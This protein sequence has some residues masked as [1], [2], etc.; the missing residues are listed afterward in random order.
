MPTHAF[1]NV[2]EGKKLPG[3]L[4]KTA[5]RVTADKAYDSNR[6]HRLLNDSGIRSAI[7][8]KRNRLGHPLGGRKADRWIRDDQRKRRWTEPRWPSSNIFMV[9]PERDTG[10]CPR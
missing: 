8:L 9:S 4:E 5:R 3:G 10:P 6:N 7:V 2:F 1:S